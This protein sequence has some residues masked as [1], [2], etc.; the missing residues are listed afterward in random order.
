MAQGNDE[1]CVQRVNQ[2]CQVLE[3]AVLAVQSHV[4]KVEHE[5]YELEVGTAV[6]LMQVHALLRRVGETTELESGRLTR[7]LAALHSAASGALSG[8]DAALSALG[9]RLGE[10]RLEARAETA[11]VETAA[12]RCFCAMQACQS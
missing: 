8:H 7:E 1:R 5:V 9:Q 6:D 2:V 12:Q 4:D 3:S 11:S 10:A